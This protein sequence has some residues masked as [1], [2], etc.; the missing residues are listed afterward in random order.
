LSSGSAAGADI[1]A[2]GAA[3]TLTVA[4]CG[5]IIDLVAELRLLI[6]N[7]PCQD[8]IEILGAIMNQTL[9]WQR[10]A[11]RAEPRR[12]DYISSVVRSH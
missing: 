2:A 4:D 12:T 7:A 10:D 6:A 1:G 5:R 11:L 9:I 3:Q 8:L